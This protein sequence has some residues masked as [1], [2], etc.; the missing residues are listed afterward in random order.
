MTHKVRAA[1][2]LKTV[3]DLAL[4]ERAD[5]VRSAGIEPAQV[6]DW[7]FLPV[8]LV[9]IEGENCSALPVR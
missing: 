8:L 9:V 2:L 7:R 4:V 6:D 5:L 1:D 3:D